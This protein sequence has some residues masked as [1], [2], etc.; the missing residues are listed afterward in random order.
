MHES[1]SSSV[2]VIWKGRL[3]FRC[4][5]NY[6]RRILV[7]RVDNA[8]F[9]QQF[10]MLYIGVSEEPLALAGILCELRLLNLALCGHLRREE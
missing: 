8:E 10:V 5:T 6:L 1:R 2:G 7:L 4:S 9:L 3:H